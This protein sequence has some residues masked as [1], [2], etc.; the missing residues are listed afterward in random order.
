MQNEVFLTSPQSSPKGEEDK[1][2]LLLAC[3]VKFEE[4]FTGIGEG[5]RD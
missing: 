5:V 3:P 1:I 2:L 4:Y